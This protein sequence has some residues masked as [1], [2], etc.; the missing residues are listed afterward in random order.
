MGSVDKRWTCSRQK[1]FPRRPL[2]RCKPPT[3]SFRWRL[4][5]SRENMSQLA[6]Q[7]QFLLTINANPNKQ[8]TCMHATSLRWSHLLIRMPLPSAFTK[9]PLHRP[10]WLPRLSLWRQQ[11]WNWG[12][13]PLR[14][15]LLWP[16]QPRHDLRCGV[17]HWTWTLEVGL[18]NTLPIRRMW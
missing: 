11:W 14:Q 3:L 2:Y 15:L 1:N 18:W 17:D 5:S 4:H 10:F 6:F 12:L 13:S 8:N 16:M 7:S 9:P